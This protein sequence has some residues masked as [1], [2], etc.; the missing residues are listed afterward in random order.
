MYF[1]EGMTDR[2]YSLADLSANLL[3]SIFLTC[4]LLMP[5]S[6]SRGQADRGY[7]LADLSAICLS[8][9]SLTCSP[10]KPYLQRAGRQGL[11]SC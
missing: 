10:L 1:L 4:S 9:I 7:S 3:I 2:S 11:F 6:F 8:L 5:Y